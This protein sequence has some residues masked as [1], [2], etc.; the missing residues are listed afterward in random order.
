[1]RQVSVMTTKHTKIHG[2]ELKHT[3][4]NV[5]LT[6]KKMDYDY[7]QLH[8]DNY[9]FNVKA[10]KADGYP[11]SSV[12]AGMTKI[13]FLDSFNSEA[14]AIEA[15]PDLV[16]SDG[17]VSYGSA[18]MDAPLKDVSHIADTPDLYI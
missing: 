8:Q 6:N 11:S 15:F 1:M 10:Y 9:G 5:T 18:F 3:L 7:L 13:S 16:G 17:E 2:K 4:T 14:E 12:C